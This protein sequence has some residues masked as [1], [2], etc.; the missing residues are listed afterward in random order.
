MFLFAYD[1][2]DERAMHAVS[3]YNSS[4]SPPNGVRLNF[5]TK[6]ALDV[7]DRGRINCAP[8][9]RSLGDNFRYHITYIEL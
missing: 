9:Q 6:L 3:I 1:D 8:Q 4:R 2:D 7:R 5:N